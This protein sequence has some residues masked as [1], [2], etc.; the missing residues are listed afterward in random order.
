MV[1]SDIEMPGMSGYDLCRKIKAKQHW[2]SI[3]VVLLTARKDPMDIFRG[4]ECGAD[5][6]YTKPYDPD[7]LVERIRSILNNRTL[8]SQGTPKIGAA[9][10][11]F[12]ETFT[13]GLEKEQ[14][15]EL[16]IS[17]FEDIVHTN[18]DLEKSTNELNAAK[19]KI[20]EYAGLLEGR[21][22]SSEEMNRA[23]VESVIDGII[24]IN[25][26]G[27]IG[28][29]NP[30]IETIFGYSADELIGQNIRMLMP[31]PTRD[32]HDG[33]LRRYQETGKRTIIGTQREAIGI[34][35]DGKVVPI[36][37]A[38]G[39][40]KLEEETIFV[41]VIHD[42]TVRKAVEAELRQS[43]RLDAIGQLTG[44]IAHDFNNI[45]MVIMANV[46]ALAEE[47]NIDPGRLK[48]LNRI[49]SSTQRAAD[50]TRQLLAFA[51]KQPLQPQPINLN[52]IVAVTGKMLGRALGEHIEI[53][54]IL[55]D[56]LWLTNI[57]RAQLE[58]LLV[59]LS[60]NA[61]DAMPG[62]G[63]LLI[64]TQ[65]MTLD[66]NYVRHNPEA[67]AGEYAMLAV[68]DTGEGIPADLLERVFE[69]FFT[70]KEVGKGTGLGLS[71]VYGFIKQSSGHI[72]IYSEVG[73]GTTM[74][75]YL[76]R[77]HEVSIEAEKTSNIVPRGA[78]RIL[79]VEDDNLVRESVVVQLRS[80]G[81]VVEEANSAAAGLE[82]LAQDPAYDLLLTDVVMPGQMSGRA[83]AGEATK[84]HTG[85]RVLFMS[86]YADNAIIRNGHLADSIRLLSKPF[87][88]LDLARAVRD[89]VDIHAEAA[90]A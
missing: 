3:P 54:S 72:K 58:S 79:V 76:P 73:H 64:E 38:I 34:R 49:T 6:F 14:I 30:A 63:R 53:D 15:L 11:R 82:R 51:G 67:A 74:R 21:V 36:S 56:E 52:D 66:E 20:E 48:R 77:S 84:R 83:F 28:L 81:Y 32:A 39:E 88:K 16:L 33:F 2:K 60:I 70:T 9:I 24:T 50:L 71:M 75:I 86:G 27:V 8:R 13:I 31:T 55:A 65:N 62:G 5:N 47:N 41:G 25:A 80:L 59:N 43:Q 87:Q 42:L 7:R 90:T 12:G 10:T 44:G 69:P 18:R 46:E 40:A 1:I 89:A 37:I 35:K 19:V 23:I 68:S 26:T 29:I 61:R 22:R 85:L 4:L 78:E 17:T 45:L 57:D